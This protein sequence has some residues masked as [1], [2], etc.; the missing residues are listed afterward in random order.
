MLELKVI[1]HLRRIEEDGESMSASVFSADEEDLLHG[2]GCWE[3]FSTVPKTVLGNVS[4]N[5]DC[6]ADNNDG[7][8]DDKDDEQEANNNGK[9]G[10]GDD[11]DGDADGDAGIIG[12]GPNVDD[13]ANEEDGGEGGGDEGSTE[14][15]KRLAHRRSKLEREMRQKAAEA[16]SAWLRSI[17]SRLAERCAEVCDAAWYDLGETITYKGRPVAYSIPEAVMEAATK[18]RE[19][20]E[21]RERRRYR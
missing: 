5:D 12:Q 1:D 3:T 8:D 7:H 9:G 4:V 18:R 16:V 19:E 10:G 21:D 13:N 17:E 20:T 11:G 14:E 15:A 6:N 2:L